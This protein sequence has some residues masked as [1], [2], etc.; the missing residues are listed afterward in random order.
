M[1]WEADTT[2]FFSIAWCKRQ[3][4]QVFCRDSNLTVGQ[5]L[6]V[7]QNKLF[8]ALRHRP[9]LFLGPHF[10]QKLCKGLLRLQYFQMSTKQTHLPLENSEVRATFNGFECLLHKGTPQKQFLTGGTKC[11]TLVPVSLEHDLIIPNPDQIL[12]RYKLILCL[13]YRVHCQKYTH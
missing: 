2:T 10:Q 11:L 8:R 12:S 9:T 3:L 7:Y 4:L 5:C 1:G 6:T 13:V